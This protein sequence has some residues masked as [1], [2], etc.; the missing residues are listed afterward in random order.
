MSALWP[1]LL[2]LFFIQAIEGFATGTGFTPMTITALA[3]VAVGL[4]LYV[5]LN[6]STGSDLFGVGATTIA[7]T[8]SAALIGYVAGVALLIAASLASTGNFLL[9]FLN[10]AVGG[11]A[12][13]GAV[14][15]AKPGAA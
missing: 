15:Q 3:L 8:K 2:I 7:V 12:F 4:V 5:S 9:A 6:G 14:Q 11:F 1:S 10:L 13:F